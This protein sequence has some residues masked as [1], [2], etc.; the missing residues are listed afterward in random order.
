MGK[1]KAS[2]KT[3]AM[4]VTL[5]GGV[6]KQCSICQEY[7]HMSR[8][9]PTMGKL[10][11]GAAAPAGGN[12][13]AYGAT[14]GAPAAAPVKVDRGPTP[15]PTEGKTLGE[16]MSWRHERGFGFIKIK[17]TEEEIFCHVKSLKCDYGDRNAK[18]GS[19]VEFDVEEGDKGKSAINVCWYGGGNVVGGRNTG[20]MMRFLADR[21]FGFIPPDDGG[22]QIFAGDRDIWTKSGTFT[23]GDRVEFD[24]KV[25][26]TSGKIC[27]TYVTL[28]GEEVK[29]HW[30]EGGGDE[31]A[32]EE[33]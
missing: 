12:A 26:K 10:P 11:P 21:G 5:I 15:E 31:E 7:G 2:G 8:D 16:V 22:D 13:D 3:A 4:Y 27:A 29:D 6:C 33:Y 19:K 24:I 14:A 9:C 32:A 20:T 18:V 23:D 17:D 1:T 25:K 28:E 30:A